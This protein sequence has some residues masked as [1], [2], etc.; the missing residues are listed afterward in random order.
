MTDPAGVIF[1]MLA[2]PTSPTYIFPWLSVAIPWG[3][4]NAAWELSPSAKP[5]L[6]DPASV[7]TTH[8]FAGTGGVFGELFESGLFELFC[9]EAV[10]AQEKSVVTKTKDNADHPM[11]GLDKRFMVNM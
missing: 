2:L 6:P 7:L 9:V 10:L 5:A 8:F 11:R 3:L 1:L 4:L